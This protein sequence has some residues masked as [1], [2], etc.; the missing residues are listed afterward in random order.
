MGWRNNQLALFKSL[1]RP[2]GPNSSLVVGFLRPLDS[3]LY[4]AMREGETL[5]TYSSRC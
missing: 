3:L 4:M 1:P 5:K 2:L